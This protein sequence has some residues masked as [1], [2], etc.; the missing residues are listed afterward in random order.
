MKAAADVE[1]TDARTPAERPRRRVVLYVLHAHPSIQAGGAETYG[2]QLYEA[3]QENESFEPVLLARAGPPSFKSGAHLGSPILAAGG[4]PNQYLL[5]TEYAAYDFFNQTLKDKSLYTGAFRAFLASWR[6]DVIHFQHTAF[7]GLDMLT[8]ARRSLPGASIVYT[9]HEFLPI[10]HNDG[11]MIKTDGSLCDQASPRCCNGCFP[12]F[13]PQDFFMRQLFIKAHLALVDQFV[14]P[15]RFLAD[16]YIAWGLPEAKIRVEEN[17]RPEAVGA[18]RPAP[19]QGGARRDRFGF[20]GQLNHYKGPDLAIEAVHLLEER[21]LRPLPNL[22]LHG[23]NLDYQPEEFQERFRQLLATSA[24]TVTLKG[25]YHPEEIGSLME[26]IDWVV[27][28]SRWWENSPLVIQEAFQHGRPVICSD[29]GGMA[30]KVTDGV[31]G[32]HFRAGDASSLADAMAAAAG[33]IGLWEKLSYGIPEIHSMRRHCLNLASIYS[34]LIAT[35]Q[36]KAS[37]HAG[38]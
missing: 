35:R 19:P 25:R 13:S 31:N 33:D 28:P 32:I 22:R 2:L 4:D 7:L 9:L 15:S 27:I 14:A 18:P 3:M 37:G 38:A 16:R 21:G 11:Q 20:F 26:A 34:E 29:I 24:Q 8:E 12:Q 6:P 23:T 1:R 10:C 36:R 30:E 17:G 5:H